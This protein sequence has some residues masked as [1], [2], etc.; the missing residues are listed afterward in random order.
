[1]QYLETVVPAQN[2]PESSL[3]EINV[4]TPVVR[5][6]IIPPD[7]FAP[8]TPTEPALAADI[9]IQETEKAEAAAT[10]EVTALDTPSRG[11][12]VDLK[13]EIRYSESLGTV[14]LKRHETLSW[15]IQRVYGDFNSKYFKLL[16]LANPEIVDPD[17]V[18]V[19]QTISLPAIPVDVTATD[20]PLWWIKIDETD[21]LEAGVNLLRDHPDG[22]HPVR[23]IPYWKPTSGTRFA[24]VLKQL[25]KDESSALEQ[26]AQLPA[27]LSSNGMIFSFWNEDYVYFADPFFGR[28]P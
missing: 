3:S 8:Q 12:E 13:S 27:G 21:T 5:A 9:R 6:Q 15:I 7:A 25:F 23:L 28:T 18:I 14:A 11:D 22:S 24:V 1:V 17:R 4:E 10:A 2:H 20:K 16:I 19:G 26:L